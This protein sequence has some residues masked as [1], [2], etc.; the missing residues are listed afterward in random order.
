MLGELWSKYDDKIIPIKAIVWDNGKTFVGLIDSFFVD[1]SGTADMPVMV[2]RESGHITSTEGYDD[3]EYHWRRA[4]ALIGPK[5]P[6]G[7]YGN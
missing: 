1:G 2:N 5:T 4:T 3:G 7:N 6:G